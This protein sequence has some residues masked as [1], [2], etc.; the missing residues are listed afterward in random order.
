MKALLKHE[1]LGSQVLSDRVLQIP[2]L[3]PGGRC[4]GDAVVAARVPP[5]P[6]GL[7]KMEDVALAFSPEWT[8]LGSWRRFHRDERQENC[9]GLTSLGGEIQAK[10]RDLPPDEEHPVQEP[11]EIPSHLGEDRAQMPAGAATSEEEGSLPRKQQNAT[12]S[13]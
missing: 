7:L 12:G 8:Q 10:V 9:G 1:S 11:R 4:R 6:Q 3:D 2:G 5:R 13:R